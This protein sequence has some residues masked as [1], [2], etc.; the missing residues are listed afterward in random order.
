MKLTHNIYKTC[1]LGYSSC[2]FSD[3]HVGEVT[4][5]DLVVSDAV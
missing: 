3:L 4:G 2:L 5:C 1:N